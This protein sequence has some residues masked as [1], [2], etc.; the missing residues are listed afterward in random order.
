MVGRRHLE[1]ILTE[2]LAHYNAAR[3]HRAIKLD[4]PIPLP[5]PVVTGKMIE[6]VDRLG[7]LIHEYQR[8]A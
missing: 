3:P 2:Y 7:G 1:Q 5:P 4:A 8:A 6:R